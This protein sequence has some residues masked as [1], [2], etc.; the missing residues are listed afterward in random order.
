MEY[1]DP[2]ALHSIKDYFCVHAAFLNRYLEY[3]QNTKL[4]KH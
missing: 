1:R 2:N 3:I 4:E